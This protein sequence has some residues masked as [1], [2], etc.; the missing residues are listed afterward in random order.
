MEDWREMAQDLWKV[1]VKTYMYSKK[2]YIILIRKQKQMEMKESKHEYFVKQVK[3]ER[4]LEYWRKNRIEGGVRGRKFVLALQKTIL[5]VCKN[6][7]R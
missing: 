2:K 6:N 7:L 1:Y 5:C 3:R 4:W